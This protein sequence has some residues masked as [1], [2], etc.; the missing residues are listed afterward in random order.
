RVPAA[1]AGP[2]RRNC[3]VQVVLGGRGLR[4]DLRPDG[5]HQG[6]R[7]PAGVPASTPAP[8]LRGSSNDPQRSC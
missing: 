5:R 4:V 3:L 2:V 7:R 8:S 6:Q 1:V